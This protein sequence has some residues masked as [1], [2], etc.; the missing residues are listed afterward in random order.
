MPSGVAVQHAH[1]P[2]ADRS[3][4]SED[5]TKTV[6][7][8]TYIASHFNG[9]MQCLSP[10]YAKARLPSDSV[11]I[12]AL[13]VSLNAQD[14]TM[15]GQGFTLYPPPHLAE[16]SPSSGPLTGG[17]HVLVKGANFS[18]GSDYRC[19][20]GEYTIPVEAIKQTQVMAPFAAQHQFTRTLACSYLLRSH[21]TG[22]STRVTWSPFSVYPPLNVEVLSPASG[23]SFGATVITL[24]GG[25]Y[26]NGTDYRCRFTGSGPPTGGHAAVPHA[27]TADYWRWSEETVNATVAANLVNNS[28]LTCTSPGQIRPLKAFV[29][30]TPQRPA[31]HDIATRIRIHGHRARDLV[32]ESNHW[33]HAREPQLVIHAKGIQRG[34]DYRCRLMPKDQTTASPFA[35]STTAAIVMSAEFAPAGSFMRH[36]WSSVPGTPTNPSPSAH[37]SIRCVTPDADTVNMT[38]QTRTS[39]MVTEDIAKM[40][41][42][43]RVAISSNCQQYSAPTAEVTFTY[44]ASPPKIPQP[45]R[46]PLAPLPLFSAVSPASG[47]STGNTNITIFGGPFVNGSD[48]RCRFAPAMVMVPGTPGAEA[49]RSDANPRS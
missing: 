45:P 36:P 39:E 27:P 29:E 10:S 34:V 1:D 3:T 33:T 16:L 26:F 4:A 40:G 46:A 42:P 24:T 18:A 25:P 5:T 44:F 22:S 17:T 6:V 2:Y 49:T 7:D 13:E 43:L 12:V 11:S 41:A 37:D 23:P 9:F 48:V 20:F 35:I 30:V 8:A 15:N 21:S 19:A 14:Y 28:A 31:V 47:P 32:G 38:G